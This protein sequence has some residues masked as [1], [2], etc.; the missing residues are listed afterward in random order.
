[1]NDV[2]ALVEGAMFAAVSVVLVLVG[3]YLP[4]IGVFAMFFSP[5]PI[6]IICLR[7]NLRVA[8]LG[9]LVATV[10]LALFTG[11]LSGLLYG[12]MVAITGMA[13]GWSY[14]RRLP[15]GA[16]AA[17]AS[18]AAGFWL[19]ISMLL[20]YLILRENPFTMLE[21]FMDQLISA[22]GQMPRAGGTEPSAKQMEAL[23]A[24]RKGIRHLFPAIF[25]GGAVATGVLNVLAA[26]AVL[27][28]MGHFVRP[29]PPF[30]QWRFPR[31]V[32]YIYAANLFL[33]MA[34]PR[35]GSPLLQVVVSNVHMV[36]SW[37]F[38]IHGLSFGSYIMARSRLPRPVSAIILVMALAFLPMI[39]IMAGFA[40]ALFDYRRL[41]TKDAERGGSG[42]GNP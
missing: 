7:H 23:E 11:P 21:K 39:F 8:A 38:L 22:V 25:A 20:P 19:G 24:L 9:A 42:E 17:V 26:Q 13:L 29:L 15:P 34:A 36:L 40:E 12:L 14:Q 27:K 18:A 31:S 6:S 2:R 1:M 35:L 28:R 16:T 10:V 4:V 37:G 30:Q 41:A 33:S 5:V 32:A 3:V